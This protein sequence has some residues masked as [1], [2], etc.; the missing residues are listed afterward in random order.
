MSPLPPAARRA[1]RRGLTR[2]LLAAPF[3]PAPAPVQSAWAQPAWTQP[4]WAALARDA[5]APV[6][7]AMGAAEGPLLLKSFTTEGREEFDRVHG[8]V[9]F[10]Y[11]NALAGLALLASGERAAAARIAEGLRLVQEQDRHWRDGRLR[12]AYAAGRVHAEAPRSARPPG[13]WDAAQ[14]RWLEDGYQAGSAAG[15]VAFAI[16]LWTALGDPPF[17]AAAGRAADWL[18]G[19]RAPAGYRGGTI[20]H[21]PAPDALPWVSTEQN[22]DLAVAF[23]RLGREAAAGHAAGFVRSMWLPAERRFAMGLTPEGAVN[24]GSALDAN[25]WPALAWPGQGF[26]GGLDWV[27]ARHGLPAGAPAA[28][29]V[30]LDFDDDRDGVWLEGTAQAVLLLRRLGREALAGRLAATV[31]RHRRP[32]GWIAAAS[33]PWLTTGLGTGLRPGVADFRYPARGHLAANA[34]AALAALDASPFG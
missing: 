30:G 3:L 21:E 10:T 12:N 19:L 14:G 32:D 2:A 23:A 11:D 5:L 27:L 22:L 34:W 13:W 24:P 33:I 9:A 8:E 26:E 15:P 18:E 7:A 31:A 1:T 6:R 17:R 4:A 29:L 16:L 25:L 28:E 20:G